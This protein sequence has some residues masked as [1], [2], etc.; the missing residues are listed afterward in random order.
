[1]TEGVQRYKIAKKVT[2]VNTV[3]N[4]FLG[5][6]KIVAG[7]LGA[8][9]ALLADGVHSLA[10][11]ITDVLVLL[12]ARA[13]AQGP[14][15]DHPYGHGRIET[16]VT[17][18]L[19]VFLI[20]LG[21]GIA[22]DA[23]DKWTSVSTVMT[24]PF[25]LWVAVVSLIMNE[26]LFRY[27]RQQG[28][29]CG[30]NM[31]IANAWHHRTDALSSFIVLIGVIGSL[32]GFPW[33][34]ALAA[35]LVSLLII[36]MGG[37]MMWHNLQEL[38]DTAMDA[39]RQQQIREAI[40]SVPGVVSVHELRSRSMAG[41]FFVDVHVEVD[42]KISVSEGHFVGD[43]VRTYLE[44]AFA[45]IE[46]VTIHIDPEDDENVS[47]CSHLPNRVNIEAALQTYCR[48]LAIWRC[49]HIIQ[50]HYLSGYVYIELMLDDSPDTRMRSEVVALKKRSQQ[51]LHSLDAN[52]LGAVKVYRYVNL[53]EEL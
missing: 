10:D 31:L 47:L 9:Q 45:E 48:D 46:D 2:V 4:S 7:W 50:L 34:D 38:V 42:P 19:G 41:R 35:I 40:Q 14:D 18:F 15:N 30:S 29:K 17:V 1:M 25:V 37:K 11:L 6:I 36:K 24:Q 28:E 43:Q 20:L 12:A 13:A 8:S 3:V 39:Q 5:V 27:G 23:I 53:D 52:C 32:L 49:V 16:A 22:Y 33:F 21:L 51:A 44:R 26:G